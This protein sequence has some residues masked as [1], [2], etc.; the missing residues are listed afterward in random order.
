MLG[1][2]AAAAL[3]RA[4]RTRTTLAAVGAGGLFGLAAFHRPFDAVLAIAPVL[5]YTAWHARQERTLGRIAA[6]F[7]VGG[8][9]FAILLLAYNDAVMGSVLRLPFGVTGHVDSFGFGWRASFA[10]P[11]TDHTGQIDYTI[12]RAVATA[13]HTIAVLPRFTAFAPVVLVGL[14]IAA[15]RYRRDTRMWLLVA[16]IA[17]VLVGYLF[18][19]G[20]ANAF[21]FEL[22]RS[23]G[24]F[25][26]YP[27]LV[28]LF[29]AA[30]WGLMRSADGYERSSCCCSSASCGPEWHR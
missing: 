1:T 12:G 21:H 16:M 4:L 30:A 5:A 17:T 2:A 22:E 29:V 10:L 14:G 20:T 18:W 25:Y 3:L 19:W 26:H 8:L 27:L 9:P 7:I 6:A 24:P 13:R 28:P 23:L 11:G 15:G